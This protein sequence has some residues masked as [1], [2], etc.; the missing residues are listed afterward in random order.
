MDGAFSFDIV[1]EFRHPQM[2]LSSPS[3]KKLFFIVVRKEEKSK[4]D[5]N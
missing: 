5:I 1:C 2:L 4:K 3:L